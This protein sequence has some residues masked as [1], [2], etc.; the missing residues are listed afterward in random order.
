MY[1]LINAV[2]YPSSLWL[3]YKQDVINI[4]ML[5]LGN[6][7]GPDPNEANFLEAQNLMLNH[8]IYEMTHYILGI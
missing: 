1:Y 8:Q 5:L 4:Q 6:A 3:F 2:F 7:R